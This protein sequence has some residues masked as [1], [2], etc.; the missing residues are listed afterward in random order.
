MKNNLSSKILVYDIETSLLP[1]Y[2]FRL[3]KQVIRPA[4]LINKQ[5]YT[6]II[7]ASYGWA[8][9]P[10]NKIKTIGYGWH[11]RDSLQIVKVLDK[12][13]KEA[14][15]VIGKNST[16]FDN[17]HLNT[18]RWLEGGQ[19]SPEWIR[20]T[21]DV[22]TQIR[23]Y[24]NLPSYALDYLSQ[25]RGFGGKTKMQ[26]SDWEDIANKSNIKS[27]YKMLKYC[28]K[29][30]EDT[31]RLIRDVAPH[32]E[33][34]HNVAAKGLVRPYKLYDYEHLA[35]KHCGSANIRVNDTRVFGTGTYKLFH[36]RDH[37]GYAG[38]VRI[39]IKTNKLGTILL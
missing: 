5:D 9:E 1:V 4:Q 20:H 14:D 25:L 35:C 17:K 24:F 6:K 7:C 37:K 31:I 15:V 11:K 16:R 18:I 30:V 13:I 19:A 22:E 8:H 32:V 39:N 34:K 3:G 10:L 12:H 21:D 36:C 27:Y 33:W 38:R 28:A 2:V 23:K 26:F 29:D